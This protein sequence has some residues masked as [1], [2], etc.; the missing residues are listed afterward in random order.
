MPLE[1][2]LIRFYVG[3]LKLKP[4][5]ADLPQKELIQ[6]MD[7]INKI[8]HGVGAVRDHVFLALAQYTGNDIKRRWDL[9]FKYGIIL[10]IKNAR[11][12]TPEAHKVLKGLFNQT[13]RT[14]VI[15]NMREAA[16][17]MAINDPPDAVDEFVRLVHKEFA[18]KSKEKSIL[19]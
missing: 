7:A 14:A 15:E 1:P 8:A 3:L 6:K 2:D 17:A 11:L 18:S 19:E 16:R 13:T 9:K 12:T 10:F 5:W 4:E